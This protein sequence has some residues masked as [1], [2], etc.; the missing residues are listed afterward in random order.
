MR[1]PRRASKFKVQVVS[2]AWKKKQAEVIRRS[3][4]KRHRRVEAWARRRAEGR[5]RVSGR[6]RQPGGVRV[7]TWV[8]ASRRRTLPVVR[9]CSP[10]STRSSS[11]EAARPAHARVRR[12]GVYAGVLVYG[13]V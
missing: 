2:G 1:L 3:V 11:S 12:S 7:G 8:G 4:S 13:R 9:W 10:S 6:G 5:T